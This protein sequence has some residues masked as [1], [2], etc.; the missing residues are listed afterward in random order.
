MT[1]SHDYDELEGLA[2][3]ATNGDWRA[4]ITTKRHPEIYT[5]VPP[6]NTPNPK[7]AGDIL[8]KA[9]A[10]FIAAANPTTILALIAKAR[11]GEAA[12][13]AL[14]GIADCRETVPF[15][16]NPVDWCIDRARTALS[17]IR[18]GEQ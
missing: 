15:G 12:V 8:R 3:A 7:V 16:E 17:R 10:R 5:N 14:E 2:K 9:D 4:H 1:P 13:E 6:P 18:E 11:A